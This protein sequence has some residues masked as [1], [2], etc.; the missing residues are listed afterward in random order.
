MQHACAAKPRNC[1]YGNLNVRAPKRAA[2]QPPIARGISP[3]VRPFPVARFLDE[4]EREDPGWRGVRRSFAPTFG[5]QVQ[6]LKK[7][8]LKEEGVQPIIVGTR[9]QG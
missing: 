8:K 4:K 7:K 6:V 5:M 1:S 3:G 2:P 9:S